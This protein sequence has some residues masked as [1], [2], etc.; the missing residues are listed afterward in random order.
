MGYYQVSYQVFCEK[1]KICMPFQ[2]HQRLKRWKA[3][4]ATSVAKELLMPGM[5]QTK[6]IVNVSGITT[7][8]FKGNRQT[9]VT[10]IVM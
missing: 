3:A 8:D 4:K 1:H 2:P 7:S 6:L 5:Y 10:K 9:C